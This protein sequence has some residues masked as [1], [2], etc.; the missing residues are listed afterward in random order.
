MSSWQQTLNLEKKTISDK[1]NKIRKRGS[2]S[3]SSSS[4]VRRYRFKRAV[5]VPMWNTRT[6]S[7]SIGT[8][9]TKPL[10]SYV[11][12]GKEKELS[13][14]T[15]KL[16]A[17][18]WEVNDLPASRANKDFNAKKVR[19]KKKETRKQKAANS[20][21]LYLSDSSYSPVSESERM[22]GLEGEGCRRRASAASHKLQLADYYLGG[23]DDISN[24]NFNEVGNQPRNSAYG[25]G[26]VRVKN[27]LN[28]ARTGLSTAK[29]LVKALNQIC[30]H[31][32]HSSTLPLISAL[33]SELDQVCNQVDQVIQ[34]QGSKQDDIEY[35]LKHFDEEK[36]TRKRREQG[37][38]HD[39]I[40]RMA[41]EIEVEKKLR[42]QTERLNK[43]IAQEMAD[44][45]DSHFKISQELETERRARETLEQICDELA[46]GI[47]EDRA[48]VEELKRESAKVRDEVEKEREMLQFADVLREE[49]VQMKLSEARYQFEEKNAVFEK[50]RNEL[51]AFLKNKDENGDVS[52]LL[53]RIKDLGSYLNR[54]RWGSKSTE[55]KVDIDVGDRGKQGDESDN[56]DLHSIE[57]SLDNNKRSYKWSYACDND[58][59][60][61]LK[62]IS[63][64]DGI[65]RKS[66]S[67][68]VQWGNICFNKNDQEGTSELMSGAQIL[69]KG[70][71]LENYRCKSMPLQ[72][73]GGEADISFLL[74]GDQLKQEAEG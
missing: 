30:L 45:K 27:S 22:K 59:G 34:E 3:S 14:S 68:R 48:K 39:A 2:S 50:L 61:E 16:A 7:P 20:L 9:L 38:V 42:R 13:V 33:R 54:S 63:N 6:K 36:A 4:L 17:T 53:K 67:E 23:F 32:H 26:I 40:L 29:K 37:K 10:S 66:V 18:L 55:K 60:D 58:A 46:K 24:V 49:R 56:S 15:R 64:D 8:Q 70:D 57:L 71:G 44:V 1:P 74:E 43:N 47:G 19:S 41:E 25:K 35:L 72:D 52:P 11:I 73:D 65:G 28:K 5:L 21:K 69:D 31:E 62:R 12:S 51:E